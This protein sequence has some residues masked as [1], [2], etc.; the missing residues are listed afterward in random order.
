MNLT[1]NQNQIIESDLGQIYLI[2]GYTGVGKTTVLLKK[3]EQLFKKHK[4]SNNDVIFIVSDELK[5]YI[6]SQKYLLLSSKSNVLYIYTIN[7]LIYKYLSKIELPLFQNTIDKNEK[8]KILEDIILYN[9][10]IKD[11]DDL[12]ID[13]IMDEIN[14]IQANIC[15]KDEAEI[16]ITLNKELKQYLITPRRSPHKG[17]LSFKEKE[18]IWSVYQ[19][20]INKVLHKDIF[21]EE[22][23][24]QSFLRLLFHQSESNELGIQFGHIFI[25]DI[26]DFSKVQLDVLYCLLKKDNPLHS[27]YLT[28]DEIKS[29]DRYKNY[30]NSLLF[31]SVNQ[32]IV[33][34]TNFRNSKN[35]F[36]I[37]KA[38]LTK[39]ELIDPY[40]PYTCIKDEVYKSTLTFYYNKRSDEKSDV[41]F[42]RLDILVK[43]MNYT[44]KDILVMFNDMDNLT[45]IKEQCQFNNIKVCDIF[46]HHEKKDVN[47]LTFVHKTQIT[48]CEFK[49]VIIYDAENKKLCNGPINKIININNN[50]LDSIY[51]YTAL[52]NAT[53]FLII[54]SSFS[55][56]SHLLL[57]SSISYQDFVF[58]VGSKFEIKST[59]NVYRISD[60]MN[61]I[62]DNLVKYYG[63]ST[64]D[65][66]SHPTFDL[67]IDTNEINIGIK[68]LDNNINSEVIQSV[69]NYGN[70]LTYIVIFDVHHYLT[71]KKE[72]Q[73]FVRVVDI[74]NK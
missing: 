65:F 33:L 74:P 20:F 73:E 38:N 14:F 58:E 7:E 61:F 13:F 18:A 12:N 25:D 24:Y 67:L 66:K 22:T 32:T 37:I 10:D 47:A 60:F 70:D 34:D 16:N 69:L 50:F 29:K 57:P 5:K 1:D 51:F 21:D 63:Y 26:Q 3:Y 55:E 56:P 2:E 71:F 54:N 11:Y 30:K 19:E 49:V 44:Y 62:K 59:L 40:L 46:D 68:I 45:E 53:D 39:N 64:E 8:K 72:N 9:D 4:I 36:N 52:G 28:H 48:S 15:L 41:F 6:I 31:Q 17:L 23:F 35:V 42:D 27:C 43:N